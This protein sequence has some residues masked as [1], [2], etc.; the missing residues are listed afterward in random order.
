MEN[1][2]ENLVSPVLVENE[3]LGEQDV[4]VAIPSHTKSSRVENYVLESFR[5]SLKKEIT[6]EIKGL[7]IESQK[8]LLKLLKP[9]TGKSVREESESA[10][11]EDSKTFYTPTRSVKTH[12]KQRPM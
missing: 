10:I 2:S 12:P 6:S 8:E 11:E 4:T 7:L 3:E 5:A 9:R 1:V